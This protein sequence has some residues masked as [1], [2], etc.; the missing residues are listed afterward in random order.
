MAKPDPRKL[1]CT[2]CQHEN[3]IERVYCHNCGEKLDRSLLPAIDEVKSTD[4]LA[5]SRKKVKRMMNPNRF[6]WARSIR[7]FVLIEIFAAIVAAG[8]L[9][10]QP[11]DN[12]PPMKPDRMPSVEAKDIWDEMMSRRPAVTVAFTDLDVNY[13]LRKAVKGNPGPLGIKFDRAFVVFE[14]GL[15]TLATQ[16]DAW[17]LKIYNSVA[18]KPVLSGVKWSADVQR[19]TIGRLTIPATFAK[20]VK[21]DNLVQDAVAKV[22]EK[23]IRQLDRVEKI[24]VM[25]NAISFTTK[26]A[27]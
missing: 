14:P 4:D 1:V 20:L 23:E 15:A 10:S 6:A 17:G 21:L 11:P 9:A 27:Q 25:Q 12:M 22:F 5:R 19:V 2:A 16:R 8:F 7:T 24:E 18:F 13:Y 26:P 3:E